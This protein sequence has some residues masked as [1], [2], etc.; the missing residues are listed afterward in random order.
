M[1]LRVRRRDAVRVSGVSDWRMR[2]VGDPDG[3]RVVVPLVASS[4][5]A[6]MG[7]MVG[8]VVMVVLHHG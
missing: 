2:L 4:R 8:R 6:R 1:C 7:S 5:G 3:G